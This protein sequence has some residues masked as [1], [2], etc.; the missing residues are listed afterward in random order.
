[1]V[2]DLLTKHVNHVLLAEPRSPPTVEI[3][4]RLVFFYLIKI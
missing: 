3:L 2:H 1:M 4:Q